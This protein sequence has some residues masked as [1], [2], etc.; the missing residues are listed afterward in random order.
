MKRTHWISALAAAAGLSIASLTNADRPA[1][2]GRAAAP[3]TSPAPRAR[4]R[5]GDLFDG[6]SLD[7]WT[8]P[9]FAGHADPRMDDGTIVLPMG[10][11]LT[12]VNYAKPTPKV[13]LEVS[14]DAKRVARGATSC[15]G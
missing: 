10:E 1:A 14:L 2:T 6:K 7:G 3:A 8:V 4:G 12:G 5:G 15:P 9:D 13:K 11:T